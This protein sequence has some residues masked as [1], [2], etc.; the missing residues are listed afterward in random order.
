[1]FKSQMWSNLG[2]C[3]SRATQ[4]QSR[5]NSAL[6]SIPWVN[7]RLPN[8]ALI[9]EEVTYCSPQGSKFGKN[10][11][12]S[13][14]KSARAC[15]QQCAHSAPDFIQIGSLLCATFHPY[16]YCGRPL[17][18]FCSDSTMNSFYF[19]LLLNCCANSYGEEFLQN[20][21][22]YHITRSDIRHNFSPYFYM[23]YLMGIVPQT[24]SLTLFLPQMI[25]MVIVSFK[26][27]QDV[28]FACFV[29]T[30]IFVTFNKVCTSQVCRCP[31][32]CC[33]TYSEHE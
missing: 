32:L 10:R 15:P 3:F 25:L 13:R 2:F 6:N 7:F 23:L 24:V 31:F 33:N 28:E 21:Y 9:G 30:F 11:N 1:M 12:F 17:C 27:R 20:A 4:N 18:Q 26:Y 5:W 22:W 19:T 8:L 16:W 14:P 29:Q